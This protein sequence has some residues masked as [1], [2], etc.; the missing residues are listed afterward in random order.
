[1]TRHAVWWFALAFALGAATSCDCGGSNPDSGNPPGGSAGESDTATPA[2]EVATF[3]AGALEQA[4]LA[5]L[6]SD[7]LHDLCG[8]ISSYAKSEISGDRWCDQFSVAGVCSAADDDATDRRLREMCEQPKIECV[9]RYDAGEQGVLQ[10]GDVPSDVA[11]PV[12]VE[13]LETCISNQVASI[14]KFLQT[15]PTC[16]ELTVDDCR[17]GAVLE[18]EPGP[19]DACDELRDRC[20]ERWVEAIGADDLFDALTKN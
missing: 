12:S 4:Q 13:R 3:D 10:C 9:D 15:V 6:E 14:R 1:M 11:C 16:S 19:S 5:D 18:Y 17:G 2:V 7:Q 8:R 20:S